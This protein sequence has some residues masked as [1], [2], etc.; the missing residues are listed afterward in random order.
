VITQFNITLSDFII[1]FKEWEWDQVAGGSDPPLPC[2][3]AD[4]S[5]LS[6]D[7][8]SHLSRDRM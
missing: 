4:N 6:H 3:C 8:S 7:V 1:G 2:C 5:Q